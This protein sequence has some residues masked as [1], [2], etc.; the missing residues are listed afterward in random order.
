MLKYE[1][2]VAACPGSCSRGATVPPLVSETTDSMQ[3]RHP[4]ERAPHLGLND[5]ID[6]ACAG[7]D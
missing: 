1:E 4:F 5:G 7:V 3:Y 2:V 6:N